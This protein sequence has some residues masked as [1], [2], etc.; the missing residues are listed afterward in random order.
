MRCAIEPADG[1]LEIHWWQ[2]GKEK[3]RLELHCLNGL[4]VFSGGGKEYLVA[5]F[6]D[7]HLHP[8]EFRLKPEICLRWGTSMLFPSS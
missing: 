5:T 3:L 4:Q 7:S 1:T 2:E 6:R 8:L